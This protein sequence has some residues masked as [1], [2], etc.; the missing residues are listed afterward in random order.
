M[1]GHPIHL[2]D[3]RD[4]HPQMRTYE[5]NEWKVWAHTNDFDL[6]LSWEM[7]LTLADEHTLPL[8]VATREERRNRQNPHGF[9]V[10]L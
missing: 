8:N 9:T 3:L 6:S 10:S 7:P 2:F 1:N 5:P 4:T